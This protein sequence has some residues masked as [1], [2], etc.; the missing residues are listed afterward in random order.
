MDLTQ[1][2][3]YA[4]QIVLPAIGAAGQQKLRAARVLVVGAGGLGAPVITY[5]A[6]CGVGHLGIIDPDRVELSNLPRQILFETGDIGRRKVEAAADRIA[7]LNPECAVTTYPFA[8][9]DANARDLIARYHV[10]ADGCDRFA[11]R[12]T[13][14]TAC[15]QLGIPLVSAAVSGFSGQVMSV[16]K[17]SPCYQC[18]V[19]PDA[20]DDRAC[21]VGILAPFAGIVGSM[22]ALEVV[23]MILGFPALV[24]RMAVLDGTTNTQRIITL[25]PDAACPVHGE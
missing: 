11:A 21:N 4:R 6:S 25:M 14:N 16:V 8:L 20:A 10:V 3:R 18:V 17:D 5:L 2:R 7:E 23:R 12:F 19:H 9:D 24:G 1:Q 22:Q 15:V 13:V